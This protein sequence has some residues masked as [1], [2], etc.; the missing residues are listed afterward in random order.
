VTKCEVV[1]RDS[2]PFGFNV[3]VVDSIDN[4]LESLVLET[5]RKSGAAREAGGF[6]VDFLRKHISCLAGFK[7]PHKLPLSLTPVGSRF[8]AHCKERNGVDA[9]NLGPA[10]PETLSVGHLKGETDLR[11]KTSHALMC[12]EKNPV[13]CTC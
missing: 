4:C 1:F 8:V 3:L 2:A 7:C 12:S 5:R 6:I 10:R 9:S 11:Q 13:S